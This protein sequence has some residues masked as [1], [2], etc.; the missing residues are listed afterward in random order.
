MYYEY[1]YSFFFFFLKLTM[2]K[3]LQVD[4][5]VLQLDKYLDISSHISL[6]LTCR[7][8]YYLL[9]YSP[10]RIFKLNAGPFQIPDDDFISGNKL[11][12]MANIQKTDVA[13]KKQ[14]EDL[15]T[16]NE[17][18][19]YYMQSMVNVD[20]V[21][22]KWVAQKVNPGIL[23]DIRLS[24]F[25][26]NSVNALNSLPYGIQKRL[27]VATDGRVGDLRYMDQLLKVR[28]DFIL[29]EIVVTNTVAL[30]ELPWSHM[31][32][33]PVMFQSTLKYIKDKHEFCKYVQVLKLKDI[34]D[35]DNYSINL[36]SLTDFVLK[37]H[38]LKKL[39]ILFPI[40]DGDLIT[41]LPLRLYE[42]DISTSG[43]FGS[44][45]PISPSP[46]TNGEELRILKISV[47]KIGKLNGY[48]FGSLRKLFVNFVPCNY[49][50][51]FNLF[52]KLRF[53]YNL[54]VVEVQLAL[55]QT[56]KVFRAIQPVADLLH[57]DRLILNYIKGTPEDFKDFDVGS[58]LQNAA[59]LSWVL[60]NFGEIL[61]PDKMQQHYTRHEILNLCRR[62]SCE[63]SFSSKLSKTEN[64]EFSV[65]ALNLF[66]AVYLG[67]R[68]VCHPYIT[69]CE[70][71]L[72]EVDPSNDLYSHLDDTKYPFAY[73]V[74]NTIE[75]C[76]TTG[77]N[78]Q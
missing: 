71:H 9:S 4:E 14:H 53:S 62:Y 60:L 42:L 20:K 63:N 7:Y 21:F 54:E 48:S 39:I 51:M 2:E 8:F 57:I 16:Y 15:L 73:R 6:L 13:I 5:I 65:P 61:V 67:R 3:L 76:K 22:L 47:C 70:T 36:K 69:Y 25:D 46:Q 33:P 38:K 68:F 40:T 18:F 27:A 11:V 23:S 34:S 66:V 17:R 52:H 58:I 41:W 50:D 44:P 32:N 75:S 77:N 37:F 72:E 1:I 28:D 24:I 26:Q 45:N 43:M 19:F 35:Q 64:T 12:N 78:L 30:I 59:K 55:S 29:R 49:T 56:K 31:A 10:W 74:K